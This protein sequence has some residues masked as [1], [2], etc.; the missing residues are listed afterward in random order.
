MLKTFIAKWNYRDLCTIARH[1][2]WNFFM[3]IFRK[4][5]KNTPYFALINASLGQFMEHITIFQA[6]LAWRIDNPLLILCST[7]INSNRVWLRINPVQ[8]TLA[9]VQRSLGKLKT[10][11]T[12]LSVPEY[13]QVKLFA[14]R[15][16]WLVS[17]RSLSTLCS[18]SHF[19]YFTPAYALSAKAAASS[20]ASTEVKKLESWALP[21]VQ[22]VNLLNIDVGL[23]SIRTFALTIRACF[24]ILL[25]FKVLC[26]SVV[27]IFIWLSLLGL[28]NTRINNAYVN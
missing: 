24:P 4:K 9:M 14:F 2:P 13:S 5:W 12:V 17:V 16:Q 19:R 15:R 28:N 22:S 10:R 25:C 23:K 27:L 26:G 1:W 3:C 6:Q 11:S 21:G 20:P 7:H 8:C 18:F